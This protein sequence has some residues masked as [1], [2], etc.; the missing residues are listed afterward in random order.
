V[1]INSRTKGKV[2]E[3]EFAH[4]LTAAGFEAERGQQHSGGVESPDVRCPMLADIHFEVK[5][6][7]SGNPYSWVEQAV[8]DGGPG[9]YHIV[10]H[11]RNHK[12]WLAI[13][14]MEDLM[15]LLI[16]RELYHGTQGSA[17]RSKSQR[18][19]AKATIRSKRQRKSAAKDIQ[20]L[21]QGN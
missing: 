17:I 10:A 16:L 5:R 1:K 19:A 8:R 14:P 11:R 6:V 21:M 12:E 9:K 13:I 20:S 2:G 4:Y 3:L 15:R 18:K 7:Q